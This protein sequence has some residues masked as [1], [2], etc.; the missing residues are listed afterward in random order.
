MGIQNYLKRVSKATKDIKSAIEEKGVSV[1]QCDGFETLADKVR[2]IQVGSSS[3][4]STLFTVLAFKSSQTKPATPTGG[5]FTTSAISYP[6]GWSDGSGLSKYVWM[7]YIVFKGDGS[8]YK[9][10]V[11][12]I[13][14]NGIINDDGDPIDL[15]DLATRTW[16]TNQIKNAI[17]NGIID[18]STYATKSYVDQKISEI[19]GGGGNFVESI[20]GA[21]GAITFAGSGVSKSG[22]TFT[23]NSGSGSGTTTS[24]NGET[25]ELTF[26]GSG[27]SKT[28]KTFTFSGGS[29]TGVTKDYVDTQDASTLKSAKDYADGLVSSTGVSSLNGLTGAVNLVKGTDNV[30]IEEEGK[31]IKISV[32]ASGTDGDTFKEFI[33]YTTSA[34]DSIAPAVPEADT[35]WDED[36]DEL[37]NLPTGWRKT[38]VVTS[39]AKYVWQITGIFSMKTRKIS[40][41]WYGPI[42]LT[43]SE[44]SKGEDG[45]EIEE[46]YALSNETT[47]PTLNTSEADSNG[48]NKTE[49][50]YLPK[51][52]FTN[53]SKEAVSERP[54]ISSSNRYLFGAKRRKH[55]GTWLDFSTAYLLANFVEAGL[56]DEEKAQIKTDVTKD[57]SDEINQAEARVSAVESRVDS[58]DFTKSTFINDPNNALI[59]AITQY[60][61]S[62]KKSFADLVVD[63]KKAEIKTWAGQ[64]VDEKSPTGEQLITKITDAGIDLNGAQGIVDEWAT[65]KT[66]T[67]G[68]ETELNSVRSTLNAQQARIEEVAQNTYTDEQLQ[69][70]ITNYA[71]VQI[72]AKAAEINSTVAKSKWIWGVYDNADT[73]TEVLATKEYDITQFTNTVDSSGNVVIAP[74]TEDAYRKTIEGT[75][76][77]EDKQSPKRKWTRIAQ[78]EA[79]SK[80]IQKTNSLTLAVNEGESW[81]SIVAKANESTGSELCLDADRINLSGTTNATEAFIGKATIQ[82][83]TITDSSI[84]NAKINSCT[85]NSQIK[86]SNYVA[87][88][89]TVDGQGFL[90][91]AGAKEYAI[92]GRTTE[93]KKFAITNN[94]IEVPA[95]NITNLQSSIAQFGF[96]QAGNIVAKE[97]NS[98]SETDDITKTAIMNADKFSVSVK[99]KSGE[100]GEIYIGIAPEY[101]VN[102][103]TYKNM[104]VLYMTY[105]DGKGNEYTRYLDPKIWI[106]P[107][108]DAIYIPYITYYGSKSGLVVSTPITLYKKMKNGVAVDNLLYNLNSTGANYEPYTGILYGKTITAEG[109]SGIPTYDSSNGSIETLKC[110]FT[111][112]TKDC[113]K[114]PY[115]FQFNFVVPSVTKYTISNG[116]VSS[117]E[118][119]ESNIY[120]QID[121]NGEEYFIKTNTEIPSDSTDEYP[122]TY[123]TSPLRNRDLVLS[124][125]WYKIGIG[126][127]QAVK[128][129]YPLNVTAYSLDG[130]E[131]PVSIS[132]A[133]TATFVPQTITGPWPTN[134][135]WDT[136]DGLEEQTVYDVNL[137]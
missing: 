136:L 112:D 77:K 37:I 57:I 62:N 35:T 107:T 88:T 76:W 31:N 52:V 74:M 99:G 30:T 81:A 90:L 115:D 24:I 60:K 89:D 59:S 109:I 2:A 13:L 33:L 135:N 97:V 128:T 8:V 46:V 116:L 5:S 96:V 54:S 4:G 137:H 85:I 104:P 61:D 98:K 15:T 56:T 50:G 11:S 34:S 12:P 91:D 93:G 125:D 64:V 106:S 40:G 19:P 20:N 94:Y 25:G 29:S 17:K 92:Y 28:G 55:N 21:T 131:Q 100:S 132:F 36:T 103:V 133:T 3:D 121:T 124:K 41:S 95:A 119:R 78:P 73:P 44:G 7:S 101:V 118:I 49:D 127:A 134:G 14:V 27:V 43:G 86:S 84:T 23:F 117:E 42:C 82:G 122:G 83:A 123:E 69:S 18:L 108:T 10:W 16:V 72:D 71:G 75:E 47:V 113:G 120:A 129:T 38:V 87:K 66:K 39:R 79:F 22:N 110:M 130:S 67:D 65:Y 53:E 45:D 6:S 70:K 58:I 111:S 1:A 48:K 114:D 51:F 32:N 63:G 80:I 126:S 68:N 9:N 105:S 26:T 102:E